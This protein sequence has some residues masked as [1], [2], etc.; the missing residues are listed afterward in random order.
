MNGDRTSTT[1][2]VAVDVSP[3]ILYR[4]KISADSR[5]QLQFSEKAGMRGHFLRCRWFVYIIVW[6]AAAAFSYA[7]GTNFI[8]NCPANWARKIEIAGVKNCFQVTTNLYRGAQ[9]TSAGMAQLK[10]MGIRTVIN[11]RAWHSD[12][13]KVTGAGLKGVRFETEP[14]HSDAE[15]VVRFL[16]VVTD[17]N[18]LPAF[19]HCERGADRTGMFCAMYRVAVCGWTKQAAIAEMK[20]GGFGF[21][22]AWQNLVAFVE[23][24]DVE[25]LKREAGINSKAKMENRR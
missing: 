22:P 17:T 6:F 2:P 14:W 13:D 18:N 21:N 11:L 23:K 3:R 5:R 9:P 10:A 1:E 16:K 4:V 19:V 12:K 15:D 7:D 20:D 25:K 24:A 8:T